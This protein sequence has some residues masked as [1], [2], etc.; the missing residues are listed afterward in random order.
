VGEEDLAIVDF[1]RL[2]ALLVAAAA[3][4]AAP[5]DWAEESLPSQKFACWVVMMVRLM[6][7]AEEDLPLELELERK[8]E[9]L[10]YRQ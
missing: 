9:H 5:V 4:A 8:R 10:Y 7:V 1:V 3:A 6:V 2:V